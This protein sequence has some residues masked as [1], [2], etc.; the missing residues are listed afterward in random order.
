MSEELV[1]NA[2]A[3]GLFYEGTKDKL[4]KQI[5]SCFLHTLGPG[6]LPER[7]D[8]SSRSSIGYISP[9]AGYMYS[10]PIAAH[11]YFNLSLE[12]KPDTIVIIGPNH[13]GLGKPISLAP[14]RE[15]ET[16]LGRIAVDVELRN[17]LAK[18]SSVVQLDY[19]AHLY[20]HSIEVQIPFI[21]YLYGNSV[22]IL[23]IAALDQRPSTAEALANDLL[24]SIEELGRDVVIIA[25]TDMTH[26]EP[27]EDAVKKDMIAYKAM[28]T[29]EPKEL[30][31]V[32]NL[33]GISMC[34][35]LGVMVLMHIARKIGG[36]KPRLLKYATSGDVTGDKTAVVGY[37]SAVFP[38]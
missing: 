29:L 37:L 3:A 10:G 1:R 7:V 33:H 35:P 16:P 22:R 5:E 34:G 2:V 28:E 18:N 27:Y 23:A 38:I 24:Y 36:G 30:Y 9:H 6:K 20:E 15:W 25:S 19:A 14:W 26:Y 4:I 11:T 13:T 12:K 32:I 17:H 31:K 21:Q 8:G